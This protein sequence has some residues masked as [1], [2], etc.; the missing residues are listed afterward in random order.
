MGATIYA[1]SSRTRFNLHCGGQKPPLPE[2]EQ[3]WKLIAG[4]SARWG[5]GREIEPKKG[6]KDNALWWRNL[7]ERIERVCKSRKFK[8]K[9]IADSRGPVKYPL[10]WKVT[11][12]WDK[13][14]P[15]P[16]EETHGVWTLREYK[17]TNPKA[18]ILCEFPGTLECE[19]D[20]L[21]RHLPGGDVPDGYDTY[22]DYNTV[23]VSQSLLDADEKALWWEFRFQKRRK[24]SE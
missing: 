5:V 12:Y 14:V 6:E 4:E 16:S 21:Y 11:V 2:E 18:R 9:V 20:D 24:S 1:T 3:A 10:G 22:P 15:A 13:P 7:S 8:T 17:G 23:S 19:G